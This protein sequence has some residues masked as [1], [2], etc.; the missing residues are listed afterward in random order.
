LLFLFVLLTEFAQ[1]WCIILPMLYLYLPLAAFR[2]L[3]HFVDR[4]VHDVLL[5]DM[6]AS[7]DTAG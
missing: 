5:W 7:K 3:H 1:L 4:S 2:L 6:A